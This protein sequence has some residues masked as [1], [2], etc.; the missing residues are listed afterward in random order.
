ML[1][2]TSSSTHSVLII[3]GCASSQYISNPNTKSQTDLCLLGCSDLI[4][5]NGD[6]SAPERDWA[7][8]LPL[9]CY[10]PNLLGEAGALVLGGAN[11]LWHRITNMAETKMCSW[12]V[13]QSASGRKILEHKN[14]EAPSLLDERVIRTF[15]DFSWDDK[16]RW[17]S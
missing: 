14:F 5:A 12:Q 7:C 10:K 15:W 16:L 13:R 1:C 11:T 6:M 3:K 4:A 9:L 8:L 2:M 17:I